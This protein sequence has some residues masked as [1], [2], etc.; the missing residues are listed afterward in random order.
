M[1]TLGSS[2]PR[3]PPPLPPA[4]PLP[5]QRARIGGTVPGNAE[6]VG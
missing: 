3:K 4:P 2:P 6:Q 5:L 1:Q